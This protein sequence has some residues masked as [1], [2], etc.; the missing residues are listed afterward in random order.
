MN[1]FLLPVFEAQKNVFIVSLAIFSHKCEKIQIYN[2]VWI[3]QTVMAN[4]VQVLL[5]HRNP[6]NSVG[7]YN[8][9]GIHL[10][11]KACLIRTLSVHSFSQFSVA[12]IQVARPVSGEMWAATGEDLQ[13]FL[14]LINRQTDGNKKK[15]KQQII[16][17]NVLMLSTTD[18][19]NTTMQGL[20]HSL[21]N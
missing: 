6:L 14:S 7:L 8:T 1:E 12:V 15:K 11:R 3:L 4:S 2:Y 9:E 20:D 19:P 16:L 13:D 21:T 17:D 5:V 10:C 18:V